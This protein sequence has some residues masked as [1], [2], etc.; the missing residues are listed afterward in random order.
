MAVPVQQLVVRVPA[1]KHK[2]WKL[3]AV[4]RGIPLGKLVEAAVDAYLKGGSHA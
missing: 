4:K 2:R 3:E 1:T